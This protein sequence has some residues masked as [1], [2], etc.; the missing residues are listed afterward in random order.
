MQAAMVPALIVFVVRSSVFVALCV[1]LAIYGFKTSLGNKP[2]F[3]MG[4][5]DHDLEQRR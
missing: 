1:G 4:W 2:A 5:L 3:V